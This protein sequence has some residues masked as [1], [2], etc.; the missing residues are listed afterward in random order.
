MGKER[1]GLGDAQ[2]IA[3]GG[4]LDRRLFMS[5]GL[6]L[7]AAGSIALKSN[8]APLEVPIYSKVPGASFQ[9]YGEPSKF[10]LPSLKRGIGQP[11]GQLAPGAGASFTPLQALHGTIT[12]ASLHFER[13]HSGIPE[14]DPGKHQLVIHG[15]VKRALAFDLNALLRYPMVNRTM[16]IECSGNSLFQTF[17]EAQQMP[18]GM[19]NGLVSCSEWTGVMLATLLD[20]AGVDPKGK[21]I[22]AE[23]AD[24][25]GMSRSIPLEKAMDDVMVALYQNG[26]PIRPEQGFPMRLVLPGFEGNM[27]VKW[28]RRIK[29]TEGPAHSK[30]ET[31]KY[32]DLLPNGKA[33]QFTYVMGVKS[34]ITRPSPTLTMG[35]PG[36]YEISGIAWSG[37][38]KI[39]KVEVSADG[40]K[41]WVDA[42]I[43]EPALD[44]SLVR[45]RLPWKWEGA[46]VAMQSRATDDKGRVQETREKW[47]TRYSP[48]NIYHFNAIQTWK[49]EAN[50]EV[51]N[52]FV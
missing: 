36:F 8:A 46:P 39:N 14:I 38:G 31:S 7:A 49:V 4:L 33:L 11:Y 15:L 42:A 52:V 25:A 30:D 28:L 26:E 45:F 22:V 35:A 19:L 9:P 16:F 12:P 13:S 50:G 21:W 10:V 23:G 5:R 17:A 20:E 24:S 3:P 2:P 47:K 48:G 41:N 43:Q 6:T 29:V 44:K 34:V 37:A 32:T 27:S 1:M 51:K 18:V 40:G